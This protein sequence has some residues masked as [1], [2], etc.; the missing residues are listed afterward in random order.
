M[1]LNDWFI[2]LSVL[3]AINLLNLHEI[4][5]NQHI[6]CLCLRFPNIHGLSSVSSYW[7]MQ[8]LLNKLSRLIE[9]NSFL[10]IYKMCEDWLIDWL[11]DRMICSFR[12]CLNTKWSIKRIDRN[13]SQNFH[14]VHTHTHDP[15]L[16]R[17]S[18]IAAHK[19]Q[20]KYVQYSSCL[21]GQQLSSD[22]HLD[23][24]SSHIHKWKIRIWTRLALMVFHNVCIKLQH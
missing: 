9:Y 14:F 12:L 18:S 5:S 8:L 2:W 4:K 3:L 21:S 20:T 23:R 13:Y 24:S 22:Y 6:V 7:F 10:K 11:I 17:F 1:F 19:H 16:F 15:Y